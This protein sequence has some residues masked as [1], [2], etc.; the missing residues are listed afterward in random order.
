MCTYQISNLIGTCFD[1]FLSS[2]LP[3]VLTLSSSVKIGCHGPATVSYVPVP[4]H[5]LCFEQ[6]YWKE[7]PCTPWA[8]AQRQSSQRCSEFWLWPW[9]LLGCRRS[10]EF[11][12]ADT[13]REQGK[14]WV[15]RLFSVRAGVQGVRSTFKISSFFLFSGSVTNKAVL[16]S[17]FW[18]L[19]AESLPLKT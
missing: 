6:A 15:R 14:A 3:S 1:F 9:C 2:I 11:W 4:V 8:S 16:S 17:V 7:G 12:S 18:V 10:K 13:R 5:S 19:T